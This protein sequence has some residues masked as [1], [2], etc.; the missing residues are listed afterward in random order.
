MICWFWR[1]PCSYLFSFIRKHITDRMHCVVACYLKMAILT[2]LLHVYL[3]S[4]M[5]QFVAI[6]LPGRQVLWAIFLIFIVIFRTKAPSNEHEK[7][8]IG[9]FL[10]YTCNNF[11]LI[12]AKIYT[13]LAKFAACARE[14]GGWV[15]CT[16]RSQYWEGGYIT[17][18]ILYTKR[19]RQK[20]ICSKDFGLHNE[21]GF[22]KHVVIK[23]NTL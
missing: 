10:Y 7:F 22:F 2:M 17:R 3:L 12:I 21:S 11:K 23:W 8:S 16:T 15:D 9:T 20:K 1:F 4:I 19:Y 13:N 18:N 6:I 14:S 5:F